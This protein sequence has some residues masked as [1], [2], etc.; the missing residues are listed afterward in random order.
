MSQNR[1]TQQIK[2]PDFGG[3]GLF[4]KLLEENIGQTTL[5]GTVLKGGIS[6]LD[7]EAVT[8]DV[9]LKS[10]GRV[11]LREFATGGQLPEIR[12]GDYVDVYVERMEGANGE[13]VLSHERARRE[14]AW[15]ELEKKSEANEHVN[16]IIFSRVKGGFTVDL[17]GAI[18]FLP[19]SQVDIR[20]VK[21]LD[22][23]FGV[24][25]PFVILKMDRQRGNIV[26]SRRAVLE[27]TQAGAREELVG[28]LEEGAELEGVVK[29]VTDY[30]AFIDLG[31]VDGLLHVTDI[32]WQRVNHPAEVLSVGQTINVKVIKYNKDNHRI[33]LGIKQLTEDPWKNVETKFTV[34]HRLK[35]KVTNV[36]DY[37]A[38]VDIGS[39]VEGLIH[40]SE[41]S[42]TKKNVQPTQILTAGQEIEVMIL[43]IEPAKRRIALGYKQCL[44]NP[45][46]KLA[47]KYPIGS[48]LQGEI[49]NITEF[50]LFVKLTEDIDGMVHMNDLTWEGNADECIKEYR[51]GQ[52]VKV[53]VLEVD[54]Q[55]ERVAL[56]IKQLNQ[57][58]MA[59]ALEGIAKGQTVTCEVVEV[60]DDGIVVTFGDGVR[61][62]IKRAELSS[63]RTER[64][65]DRFAVGEK[66]DAKVTAVDKRKIALS[67]RAREQDEERAAME[68]YGSTDSGASLGDIL[69]AAFEKKKSEGK[70]AKASSKAAKEPEAEE[71]K[72]AKPK[73][74][75]KKK[76]EESEE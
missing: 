44:A 30:G 23:L 48:E 66:I 20:P 26:V 74:T 16:G 14:A 62:H 76:K 63:E 27:E 43:E 17:F 65:P 18:A 34:G 9:G 28:R 25:Q 54:P 46:E 47:E 42:W 15:I 39:G 59:T 56:G 71:E 72:H 5:S 50:G 12:V 70:P 19:G 29:N 61:S 37:G 55:K 2:M 4:S 3:K 51:K 67:I 32:S 60:N 6:S 75:T 45:W 7:R 31:G 1:N 58:P 36:T 10:E 11:P 53:K 24:E 40:V 38:F 64:R 13:I 49:R 22:S 35:G 52:V 21:D 68:K 73:R 69:G 57:D 8:I 33:S 41:M